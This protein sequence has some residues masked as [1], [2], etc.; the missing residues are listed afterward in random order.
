MARYQI[1]LGGLPYCTGQTRSNTVG[2]WGEGDAF[3]GVPC[4]PANYSIP[5]Q[6]QRVID[7]GGQFFKGSK[8]VEVQ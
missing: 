2:R 8:V 3:S 7:Q 1:H 4:T 6:A 5:E